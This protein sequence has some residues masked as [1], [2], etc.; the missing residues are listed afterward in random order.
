M[1]IFE[2]LFATKNCPVI[3]KTTVWPSLPPQAPWV[4][5]QSSLLARSG[6]VRPGHPWGPKT[7]PL[8]PSPG[9]IWHKMELMTAQYVTPALWSTF[10]QSK[11]GNTIFQWPKLDDMT[12]WLYQQGANWTAS[13]PKQYP[14][15]V[16]KGPPSANILEMICNITVKIIGDSC[17][18]HG[19]N[20]TN[21]MELGKQRQWGS[22]AWGLPL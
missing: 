2:H 21:Q 16:S 4:E 22:A 8:R 20:I 10:I 18:D 3:P 15:W 9:L 17:C 13:E 14:F 11:Y 1:T 12:I 6:A 19:L 7:H 5:F